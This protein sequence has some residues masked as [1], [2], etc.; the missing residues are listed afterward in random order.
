[1]NRQTD[2]TEN[3][4][5]NKG[6]TACIGTDPRRTMVRMFILLQIRST[7]QTVLSLLSF[8]CQLHR[9]GK[10]RTEV[11]Q[12]ESVGLR[13]SLKKSREKGKEG[14]M[15]PARC[16]NEIKAVMVTYRFHDSWHPHNLFLNPLL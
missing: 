15:P 1:M 14:C 16:V 11:F 3:I 7:S 4:I 5:F 8:F 13:L 12:E 10:V 2:T 6:M 9:P